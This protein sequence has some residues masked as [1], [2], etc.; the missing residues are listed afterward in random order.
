MIWTY[1]DLQY[2]LRHL[3][4]RRTPLGWSLYRASQLEMVFLDQPPIRCRCRCW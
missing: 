3:L 2:R 4:R 1:I